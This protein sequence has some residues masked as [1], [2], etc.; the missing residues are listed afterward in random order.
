MRQPISL[1]RE[2]RALSE[3]PNRRS[4]LCVKATAC[5]LTTWSYRKRKPSLSRWVGRR[6]EDEP[7]LSSNDCR[8]W[9]KSR[10][11]HAPLTPAFAAG[12]VH[13]WS[14]FR[15]EQRDRELLKQLSR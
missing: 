4:P 13:Q 5:F 15:N 9:G 6:L 12:N 1:L 7:A 8:S 10:R 14:G 2:S 3:T 11:L